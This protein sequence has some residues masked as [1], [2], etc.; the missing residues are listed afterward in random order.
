MHRGA[1]SETRN[2]DLFA[3]GIPAQVKVV[4]ISIVQGLHRLGPRRFR[5]DRSEPSIFLGAT[6]AYYAAIFR[7]LC[8]NSIRFELN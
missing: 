4:R 6:Y 8:V 7:V 2:G 5:A 1:I 3:A